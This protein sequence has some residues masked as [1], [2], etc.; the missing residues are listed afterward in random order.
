MCSVVAADRS[1]PRV[2]LNLANEGLALRFRPRYVEQRT[3]LSRV[4]PC[5]E[6]LETIGARPARLNER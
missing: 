4:V 2:F 5:F 1:A 3:L 6:P